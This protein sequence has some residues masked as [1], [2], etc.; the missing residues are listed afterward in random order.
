MK[1]GGSRALV[2][3][4]A[5][6]IG[7]H[8]VERLLSEGVEV[9]GFDSF[10]NG[11]EENLA[12]VLGRP[13]FRLVRADI[14][15]RDRLLEACRGV[16]LIVHMAAQPSVARSTEEPL[17][18][19]E[20]NALGTLNVLECARRCDVKTF[21]FASSSTVYGVAE[22]PTPEDHP[23]R[24]I[25]NYGASKV[26]GEAYC[27]SYCSLYGMRAASLRYYNVYGPR[28]RKGVMFDLLEKLRRNWRKL[29]VIGDGN[30]RKDYLYISDAVEATMLVLKR[31]RLEGE[32]YNV[33][34][35]ES[36]TV[37]EIVEMILEAVGLKGLTGVVYTGKS[38]AGDV[39]VTLADVSRLRRIGFEPK[40]HVREGLGMF[41]EWYEGNYGK[42]GR[43][44]TFGWTTI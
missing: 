27:Q 37:R 32:A 42:V 20:V 9:V 4:A 6:F 7:S 39:P 16:D 23:L 30:Q 17:E 31:G 2:T 10:T 44:A 34:S 12:G 22:V 18:D 41:I 5:G 40:V 29:E 33:G 13:D 24:P 43:D 26:A 19:F 3:G 1:G 25:S 14:R 15:D 8:V 38:W 28:S 21:L 35:G 11:Y 36:L